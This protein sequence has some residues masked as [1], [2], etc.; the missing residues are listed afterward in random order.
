MFFFHYY[1][2]NFIFDSRF[3]PQPPCFTHCTSTV[4]LE[5]NLFKFTLDKERKVKVKYTVPTVKCH[6]LETFI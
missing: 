2:N 3:T 5:M 4:T 6:V 1:C